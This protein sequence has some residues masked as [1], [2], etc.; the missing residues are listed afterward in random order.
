[1]VKIFC[2]DGI[3][4]EIENEVIGLWALLTLLPTGDKLW[5]L[6]RSGVELLS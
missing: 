1:L 2:V 3:W 4:V 6:V 5:T